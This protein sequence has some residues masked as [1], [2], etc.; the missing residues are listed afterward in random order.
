MKKITF[1]QV[2][3]YLFSD[4]NLSKSDAEYCRRYTEIINYVI[5]ITGKYRFNFD[6]IDNSL[7]TLR[8]YDYKNNTGYYQRG[9]TT[10]PLPMAKYS[11]DIVNRFNDLLFTMLYKNR[12]IS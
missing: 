11:N 6:F 12:A 1:K 5:E 2:K 4:T 7:I 8:Y 10:F 3:E 9:Y